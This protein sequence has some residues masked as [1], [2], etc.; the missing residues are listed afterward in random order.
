MN[1][2]FQFVWY[3]LLKRFFP[4]KRVESNKIVTLD[5]YGYRMYWQLI[6]ASIFGLSLV[7]FGDSNDEELQDYESMKRF[8]K[9]SANIGVGGTTADD[10]GQFF[11]NGFWGKRI[12]EMIKNKTVLANVGGNNVLQNR[13][14]GLDHIEILSKMFKDIYWIN[15]PKVWHTLFPRDI[16]KDL[17]I[18]NSII[19][20]VA[21]NKLIDIESITDSGNNNTPYFFV[22]K[23]MVHFSDEFD[24][25]VRIP[26]ILSKIYGKI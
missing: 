10:W 6:I 20:K 13:M 8:P 22:L 16:V 5:E 15:I 18:A 17:K 14:S 24:Y 25:K 19:K 21:G 9:V 3:N 11:L 26:L 23:D 2:I 4:R 1:T 7:T 12:Y